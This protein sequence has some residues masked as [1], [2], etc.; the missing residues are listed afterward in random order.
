MSEIN[1]ARG[2][3][4]LWT[5][6]LLICGALVLGG[7]A[8]IKSKE[9]AHSYLGRVVEAIDETVTEQVS[10]PNPLSVAF[11]VV[12]N[13]V[14]NATNDGDGNVIVNKQSTYRRF[15]VALEQGK[16]ITLRSYVS[17]INA[18]SC[19]RVWITGP[20]VSPVYWYGP[21]VSEIEVAQDC[22]AAEGRK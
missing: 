12:G 1:L 16:Q 6:T 15:K 18:G 19:V 10:R 4:R 13:V 14:A 22:R 20:G 17:S 3:E 9:N 7:C 8:S 2:I 11:G 5:A 21:D